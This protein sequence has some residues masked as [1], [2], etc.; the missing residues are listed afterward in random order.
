MNYFML[1]ENDITRLKKK[2]L[3]ISDNITNVTV[4]DLRGE[5]Q[6]PRVE[7]QNT[8]VC[9]QMRTIPQRTSLCKVMINIARNVENCDVFHVTS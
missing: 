2:H 7:H 9:W 5:C 6:M 1:S 4:I 8:N 3:N